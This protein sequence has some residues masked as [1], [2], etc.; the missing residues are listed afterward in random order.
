MTQI[1]ILGCGWLGLPL[2]KQLITEEYAI[3]GST[4]SADKIEVLLEAGIKPYTILLSENCITGAIDAFLEKSTILI[5]NIPPGLRKGGNESFVKKVSHLISAIENSD[6]QKILFVSS[7]SV[8]GDNSGVV[9]ESTPPKPTTE[10]GRQ[11]LETE[12]L[13]K[14]NNHFTTTIL[15]FG[16]LIGEDRHPVKYMAGKTN[17][18]EPN[19]PVNLIHQV[20]CIGIITKILKT[21]E[22]GETFNAVAPYHPARQEYYTHIAK[23]LNLPLP[24]FNQKNELAMKRV[25]S[26]K[27]RQVLQYSFKNELL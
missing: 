10:S 3:K 1:S 5:I 2:A 22:W 26:Q 14:N 6:I 13:L 11:L 20:D 24:L 7:T 17:L 21:S 18:G 8:Y 19:A 15:R 9:T 23:K 27:I 25:A 16:G 4:T 12:E